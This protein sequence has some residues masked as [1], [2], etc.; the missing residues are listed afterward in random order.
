MVSLHAQV[1]S[2][3]ADNGSVDKLFGGTIASEVHA[4]TELVIRYVDSEDHPRH[5]RHPFPQRALVGKLARH[6]F[7]SIMPKTNLKSRKACRR[8]CT[9]HH[10]RRAPPL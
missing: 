9:A 10:Q 4:G 6:Q 8:G 1:T 7:K 5:T 3:I 2:L